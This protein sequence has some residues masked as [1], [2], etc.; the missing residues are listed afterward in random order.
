MSEPVFFYSVT[1]ATS[2]IGEILRD[3]DTGEVLIFHGEDGLERAK[4]HM[5]ENFPEHTPYYISEYRNG[6]HNKSWFSEDDII[7]GVKIGW[8]YT[9]HYVGDVILDDD[10]EEVS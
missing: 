10:F 8:S 9:Q 4:D 5:E 1:L 6:I 2:Q 3:L 7:A